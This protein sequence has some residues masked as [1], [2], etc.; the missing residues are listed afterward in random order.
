MHLNFACTS[1]VTASLQKQFLT[2]SAGSLDEGGVTVKFLWRVLA[3]HGVG[4]RIQ[5]LPSYFEDL[6]KETHL[7]KSTSSAVT[8]TA[9]A[10]STHE[11]EEAL[12]A[13]LHGMYR[14]AVGKLQWQAPIRPGLAFPPERVGEEARFT[15]TR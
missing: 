4:F 15:D 3:K 12:S 6:L 10:P 8:G 5:E 7:Q 11:D 9:R 1:R 14:R 13:D 2:K